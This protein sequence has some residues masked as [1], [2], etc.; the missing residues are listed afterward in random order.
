M[1]WAYVHCRIASWW[2]LNVFKDL[3]KEDIQMHKYIKQPKIFTIY[4]ALETLEIDW[5]SYEIITA[6]PKFLNTIFSY[7]W[8]HHIK[9]L[10]S[11]FDYRNLMPIYPLLMTILSNKIKHEHPN[12]ILIS[13]FAVAK[14]INQAKQTKFK[15]Q[16]STQK[17][18]LYLHSPMQY[19]R[20]HH[21]EYTGK[22]TGFK[23]RLF[24]NITQYLRDR[25]VQFRDYDTVRANSKYTAGEAKKRYGIT[26]EIKYPQLNPLFL[27]EQSITEPD[28]YFVCVG[29]LVRFVR[30][31]DV[32]INVFNKTKERLLI[33]WSGPDEVY[34]KSIAGNSIIF[35]WQLNVKEY[36]PILQKSRWL[37]N[38]TKES[39]GLWTA[40]ALCLGVPVFGYNQWATPELV[41]EDSGV[42]VE[43]KT[44]PHLLEKFDDFTNITRNRSRIQKSAKQKFH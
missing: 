27:E 35:L 15:T 31:V 20:S 8:E 22:L 21:E 33:I 16:H 44:L 42:L 24:R 14:N 23:W 10:S 1:K 32:I 6:L 9:F 7:C 4:S 18:T 25:D 17:I 36:L 19:I 26:A 40:E 43:N 12:H 37:I 13:S 11:L 28:N 29:R 5:K 30:E 39:F 41:D 38:L 2:A 34:L 3:I